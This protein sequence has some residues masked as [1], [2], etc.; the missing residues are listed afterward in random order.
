MKT[1]SIHKYGQGRNKRSVVG[2]YILKLCKDC[3]N[4][5]FIFF[6][7]KVK[8]DLKQ[9]EESDEEMEVLSSDFLKMMPAEYVDIEEKIEEEAKFLFV[10]G[11]SPGMIFLR[12]A[13]V[14]HNHEFE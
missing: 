14:I 12:I 7:T 1:S 3:F 11:S 8:S 9:T 5:H 13:V 4:K 10:P 2:K 6:K